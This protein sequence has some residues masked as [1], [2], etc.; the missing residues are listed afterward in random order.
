M[1]QLSD[2]A[3]QFSMGQISDGTRGYEVQGHPHGRWRAK[4][5]AGVSQA[6]MIPHLR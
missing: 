2:T 5:L 1:K 4:R 3:A 6:G